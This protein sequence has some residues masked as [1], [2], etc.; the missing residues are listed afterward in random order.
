[1]LGDFPEWDVLNKIMGCG[2]SIAIRLIAGIRDIRRFETP[3]ALKAY[4]GFHHFK[5][6]SRARRRRGK[7]SNW[8]TPLTRLGTF[9]LSQQV[10]RSKL[11]DDPDE[12]PDN[13][14]VKYNRRKAYELVKLLNGKKEILEDERLPK[15]F[16]GR[17]FEQYLDLSCADL[18]LLKL[19]VER[20]RKEKNE[21][22]HLKYASHLK[23]IMA[24]A[25][26][27]ATRWLCQKLLEHIHAELTA[28][29]T[30]KDE[31]QDKREVV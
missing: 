15:G 4:A 18:D 21:K 29:A 16:S 17:K 26:D 3:A 24:K 9:L 12:N 7:V 13:W 31:K 1:M 10:I 28:M 14:K 23:G 8:D 19:H 6:G 11:P 2:P 22:K 25:N 30:Q 5:D 27:K 20:L